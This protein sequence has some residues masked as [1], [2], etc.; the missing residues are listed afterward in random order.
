MPEKEQATKRKGKE[1]GEDAGNNKKEEKESELDKHRAKLAAA[2]AE[3]TLRSQPITCLR[4]AVVWL[5]EFSVRFVGQVLKSRFTWFLIV[6]IVGA[7][8]AAKYHFAPELFAPPVCGEKDSGLFWWAEFYVI[9]AAWWVILGILSSVGFGTGLHSGLMFLFPHVMQVVG[10][11]E[12]CGTS[13]GLVSWYQHPCKLDCSTTYGVKD[14]STLTIF[15]LWTMV[16]IQC[17][18]W[19]FGTAVGELPPYLVSK[20]ARLAGAKGSD[21]ELEKKEAR[22]KTDVFSKMKMWTVDFTEKH[23]FLGVFLLASWPNAAFDMCGMCCGYVLMN[24]WTFFIA[25]S[26]G[27]G[28]VKVNSQAVFFVVLFSSH[29][30]NILLIGL[31]SVNGVITNVIGKDFQLKNLAEKGR[32]KL[33]RTFESQSRF[34]PQKL[35]EGKGNSLDLKALQQVYSKSDDSEDI[36]RRVLKEWDIDG[37]GALSV[38]ELQKAASRTDGKISLS[39][40]DPG[41]GASPYKMLWELFIVGLILFF[42]CG[43][44]EQLARNK[45]EELDEEE[46]KRLESKPKKESKKDH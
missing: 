30:F 9:E 40:L 18:L 41:V 29:F 2:R 33:V 8:G 38:T 1:N 3:M 23:G 20:A 27:K 24:F 31:E 42:V 17:M 45:Q 13:T 22:E 26:L 4:L 15:R 46:V 39:S 35:L 28:V 14:G 36:A 12:A 11:A 43:V 7:W 5:A 37:D 19:G 21:Y 10:A 6:P 44:V 34:S 32:L 16:T 25:C